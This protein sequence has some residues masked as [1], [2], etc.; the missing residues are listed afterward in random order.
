[1]RV[2][3]KALKLTLFL[4][5]NKT[6]KSFYFM[7]HLLINIRIFEI[8]LKKINYDFLKMAHKEPSQNLSEHA[9]Q[10]ECFSKV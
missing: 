5:Y 9:A 8:G 1:M 3:L 10:L 7:F 4:K 6:Y 2:A